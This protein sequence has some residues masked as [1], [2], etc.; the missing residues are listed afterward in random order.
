MQK[1]IKEGNIVLPLSPEDK[2]LFA[3]LVL[4]TEEGES[5]SFKLREAIDSHGLREIDSLFYNI[6]KDMCARFGIQPEKVAAITNVAISRRMMCAC[7]RS[8]DTEKSFGFSY[9][10]KVL[11]LDGL[12]SI[13]TLYGFARERSQLQV[14][15]IHFFEQWL[16]SMVQDIHN[17]IE[18]ETLTFNPNAKGGER[19]QKWQDSCEDNNDLVVDPRETTSKTYYQDLLAEC[20]TARGIRVVYSCWKNADKGYWASK[21]TL[22]GND[23][24]GSDSTIVGFSGTAGG[25]KEEAAR[26]AYLRLNKDGLDVA[27]L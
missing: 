12:D 21:V 9:D 16:R 27:P 4:A 23:L 22:K 2:I 26:K 17:N 3:G 15:M 14:F 8:I 10:K 5:E 6:I 18:A 25:S 13:A 11:H 24:E 20:A 19:I 1:D 7:F